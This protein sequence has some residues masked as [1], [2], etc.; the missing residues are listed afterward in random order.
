M[1]PLQCRGRTY[2]ATSLGTI[3]R[4]HVRKECNCVHKHNPCIKKTQPIH[5]QILYEKQTHHSVSIP[6]SHIKTHTSLY[7]CC[8]FLAKY[9]HTR[10]SHKWLFSE[11]DVFAIPY[12]RV[13]IA[14]SCNLGNNSTRYSWQ[15]SRE[16]GGTARWRYPGKRGGVTEGEGEATA[17]R[18][19][20]SAAVARAWQ[21]PRINGSRII[22]S[23]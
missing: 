20:R 10:R 22:L 15:V 23:D 13:R 8:I 7:S 12:P 21:C 16:E 9:L 19:G 6:N 14:K 1:V 4:T 11:N 17:E 5:I 2:A 3:C 18:D